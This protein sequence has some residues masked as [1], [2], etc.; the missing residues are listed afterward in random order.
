MFI[1]KPLQ[2]HLATPAKMPPL[3]LP[4]YCRAGGRAEWQRVLS[5]FWGPFETRVNDLKEVRVSDVF[6]M[7]DEELGPHFFPPPPEAGVSAAEGVG[8]AEG[9]APAQAH[10]LRKCPLCGGRLSL[11]PSKVGGFIGG[12]N[13]FRGKWRYTI[14]IVDAL[15]TWRHCTKK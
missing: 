11:K 3:T 14:C 12:C 10:D 13:S 6:D 15:H 7:L 5:D 1:F 2:Q 8:G 9:E 4:A